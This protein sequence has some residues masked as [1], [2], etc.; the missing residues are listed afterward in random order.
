[1]AHETY[2]KARERLIQELGKLG[3]K[4]KPSLKVPQAISESGIQLF[5]K[6]QA[7]YLDRH[8]LGIDI[9]GMSVQTFLY[10]VLNTVNYRKE[11]PIL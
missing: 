9:R 10:H 11:H 2:A 7:V 6:P 1:M 8:T 4:T 3:W 5:F